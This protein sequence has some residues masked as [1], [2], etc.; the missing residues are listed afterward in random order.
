M[1]RKK[2]GIGEMRRQILGKFYN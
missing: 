1:G 2:L